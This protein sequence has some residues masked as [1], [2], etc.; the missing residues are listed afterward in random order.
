VCYL[1]NKWWQYCYSSSK[2]SFELFQELPNLTHY[3]TFN[4]VWDEASDLKP[5]GEVL[6]EENKQTKES[7]TLQQI[8][9]ETEEDS[10]KSNSNDETD[11]VI[12][13]MPVT[14][15]RNTSMMSETITCTMAEEGTET[16]QPSSS[17]YIPPARMTNQVCHMLE[18]ALE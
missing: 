3:N 12:R 6:Q 16:E 11:K 2:K 14:I 13:H 7:A 8:T 9:Q 18:E 4:L 1:N 5:L 10:D 17:T 15:T